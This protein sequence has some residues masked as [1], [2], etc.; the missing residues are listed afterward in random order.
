MLFCLA[1]YQEFILILTTSHSENLTSKIK[2]RLGAQPGGAA[3]S[4]EPQ[5]LSKEPQ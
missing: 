2:L 1:L 4:K 3:L 5:A